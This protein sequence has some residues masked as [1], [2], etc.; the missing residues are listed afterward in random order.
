MNDHQT[1]EGGDRTRKMLFKG[2]R[3]L[4]Y[5]SA[6]LGA[7]PDPLVEDVDLRITECRISERGANLAP[8]D[9]EEVVQLNGATVLPGNIN[10]HMH[11]Y[12]SLTAGAPQPPREPSDFKE[13]LSEVWWNLDRCLDKDSVYL[14]AVAGAWDAVRCGTTLLFDNHSSL[15][16]VR[17]SLDEVERALGEVGVRGSLCYEVTDRA[18]KG[19][20]DV[21]LEETERYLARRRE[22]RDGCVAQFRAKIGAHAS[23]T[24]EDKT[25]ENLASL[26]DKYGTT[27]HLHIGESPED[28]LISRKR[29]WP[30]P[31]DRLANAGLLRTGAVLAHGIDLTEGELA[32]LDNAGAWLI[33]CGRSNMNSGIGRAS[34]RGWGE[35]I[36][37]GTN[38]LD[39][40]MWGELRTT[41]FRGREV[42]PSDLDLAG[43]AKLWF[44]GYQLAR[45]NFGEAFGSLRPGAPA[46][47]IVLDN[48]QKTPLTSDTWL[49]HLL[50]DFHPWDIG[51]VWVGGNR[52]YQNGDGPPVAP[53]M[54]Q[55]TAMRLWKA[56]GWV[57]N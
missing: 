15:S 12:M 21:A 30:D 47:F 46:D 41:Y 7:D 13:T 45:D 23:F 20:R 6:E 1:P 26:C 57:R 34:L 10:G 35:H 29:G 4:D 44:G 37:L 19:V 56:M 16:F 33:H 42:S 24:L 40:N 48:F 27:P 43:A 54:L 3:V 50:Y 53:T 9:G 25:L 49:S 17:G 55:E 38:A 36:A 31:L 8:R 32:R 5:F 28:R 2:G 11:L 14:S 22:T 18:G 39:Q 52:V 51:S